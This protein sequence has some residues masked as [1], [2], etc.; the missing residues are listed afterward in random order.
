MPQHKLGDFHYN[1][2]QR[3]VEVQLL[4]LSCVSN[5]STHKRAQKTSSTKYEIKNKTIKI[6][7]KVHC[8]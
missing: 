5:F 4:L 8:Y 6:S 1:L 7:S 2:D 3:K